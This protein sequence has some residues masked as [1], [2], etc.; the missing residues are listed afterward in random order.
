MAKSSNDGS[1]TVNATYNELEPIKTK[2]QDVAQITGGSSD[3]H[4]RAVLSKI[5]QVT[6]FQMGSYQA[7]FGVPVD[8]CWNMSEAEGQ[9]HRDPAQVIAFFILTIPYFH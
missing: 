8:H 6:R 3:F 7:V 4:F 1:T 5:C 9:R 2:E